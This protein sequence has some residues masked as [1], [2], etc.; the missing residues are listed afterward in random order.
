MDISFQLTW[1]KGM[2][3]VLYG[4]NIFSFIRKCQTVFQSGDAISHPQQALRLL[5]AER[6]L[7]TIQMEDN[8]HFLYE[9]LLISFKTRSFALH[10]TIS[11][12]VL[13]HM[14]S[15]LQM[16]P[17]LGKKDM[18]PSKGQ[19]TLQKVIVCDGDSSRTLELN[20]WRRYVLEQKKCEYCWCLSRLCHMAS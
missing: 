2:I 9:T 18:C 3:V 1:I 12:N 20:N 13:K 5:I 7:S 15:R 8:S 10:F 4:K 14:L 16:W 11:L 19:L 17:N 6:I